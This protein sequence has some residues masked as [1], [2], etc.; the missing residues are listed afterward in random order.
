MCRLFRLYFFF[1][2]SNSFSRSHIR[3]FNITYICNRS[4]VFNSVILSF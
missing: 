2:I 4:T 1:C 3:I